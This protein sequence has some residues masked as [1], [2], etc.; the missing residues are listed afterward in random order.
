MQNV[1]DVPAKRERSVP[2]MMRGKCLGSVGVA[3]LDEV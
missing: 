3:W 1:K 2:G